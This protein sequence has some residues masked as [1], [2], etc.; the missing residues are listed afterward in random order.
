VTLR[1]LLDASCDSVGC[2][3]RIDGNRLVIEA[4]PPDP[5]RGRTWIEQPGRT[6]PAGAQ[7]ANTPVEVVLS[8]I[9]RVAGEG[10]VYEV[11]EVDPNQPVTVD[12]SNC[13]VVRAVAMVVKAAGLKPGSPYTIRLRRPGQKLTI[14]KAIV[15][16]D[17]QTGTRP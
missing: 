10:F 3:W 17:P 9:A 2:R 16:A 8:A 13:D 12:V 7:F 15:P 5:T 14:I 11:D 1:T 6:M 4:L